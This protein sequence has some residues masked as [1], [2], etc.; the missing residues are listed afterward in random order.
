LAGAS[1]VPSHPV[2]GASSLGRLTPPKE[3]LQRHWI[4]V[5]ATHL[6]D[7][8][9]LDMHELTDRDIQ[10]SATMLSDTLPT[11]TM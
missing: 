4:R 6:D 1:I 8:L 5:V 2:P 7:L 10:S 3:L 9:V 11:A